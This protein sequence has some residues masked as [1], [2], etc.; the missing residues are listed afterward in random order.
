MNVISQLLGSTHP[1]GFM[2]WIIDLIKLMSEIEQV[3]W[4]PE[5]ENRG[6]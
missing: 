2:S 3:F 1:Q 5:K 4:N 6:F